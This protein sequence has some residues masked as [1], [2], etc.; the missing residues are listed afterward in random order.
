[1]EINIYYGKRKITLFDDVN[2]C[3]KIK[4]LKSELILFLTNKLKTDLCIYTGNVIEAINEIKT[5]FKYIEAA[6][7]VVFNTKNEMLIIKRLG[8]YDLPKG[9]LEKRESAEEGA[10]REVEEECGVSNL[11]IREKVEASYHIYSLKNRLVLKK[12]HWYL[13]DYAGNEKLI[14]QTEEDITEAFWADSTKKDMILS[15]T[16]YNLEYYFKNFL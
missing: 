1:M 3:D 5:Y 12:T 6:G 8:C 11:K 14:P 16:Y 2:K 10:L 9:K 7:G 15:D 4:E 13:M